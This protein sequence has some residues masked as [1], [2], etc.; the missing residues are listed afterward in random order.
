MSGSAEI[1]TL[2]QRWCGAED[3]GAVFYICRRCDR[4]H[5]YCSDRCRQRTRRQQL[6]QANRKHQQSVEGRLDHRDHQQAYRQRQRQDRVTDQG[7]API[8]T[9]VTIPPLW[10]EPI[11][12]QTVSDGWVRE[13]VHGVVCGR[14]G[15]DI[16]DI[17]IRTAS[18]LKFSAF[19]PG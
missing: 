10:N 15:E 13:R 6:R 12:E 8:R 3:G 7:I 11:D 14:A 18:S 1:G 16:P 4:G 2:R 9:S 19:W 5:R 17:R